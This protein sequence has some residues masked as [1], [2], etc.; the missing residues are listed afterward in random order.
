MV[1]G[2]YIFI[3]RAIYARKHMECHAF[4]LEVAVYT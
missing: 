1:I 4:F 2:V 3:H